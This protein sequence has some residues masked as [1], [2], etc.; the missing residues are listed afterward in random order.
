LMDRGN[1]QEGAL[2]FPSRS[3][4]SIPGVLRKTEAHNLHNFQIYF[5]QKSNPNL[6]YVYMSQHLTKVPMSSGRYFNANDF[7]S[8]IPFV[9]LGQ[10]LYKTA[11]KP[12]TQPYF[13]LNNNYYSVVGAAGMSNTKKLNRHIFISASPKQHN[14]TQIRHY[15]V[16]V[17][18]NI[19]H[20]PQHLHQLQH[21]LKASHPYRSANQ[22]NN[23]RQTWW[24]RWGVTLFGLIIVALL[25][26]VLC[27]FIQIPMINLLKNTPLHG[28][29]LIDFQIG[30]WF[31]FF[32]TEAITFG[33]GG[34]LVFWKIPVIST[35]YLIIYF[36][37]LFIMVNIIA[38]IRIIISTQSKE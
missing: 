32:L 7:A 3:R 1:I 33:L 19:L 22:I 5:I 37:T 15:Q 29:L 11:Y 2:I 6:S 38:A 26:V 35:R 28:D 18:G 34:L 24:M 10:D 13:Q 31:K 14:K 17:D 8:P 27:W 9:I 16:V 23:I 36:V 12:Q 25:I 21:L 30:N 20:H 4:Q